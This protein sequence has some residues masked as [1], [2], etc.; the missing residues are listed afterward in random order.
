MFEDPA[1]AAST[2]RNELTEKNL[3]PVRDGQFDK[4][5]E[6]SPSPGSATPKEKRIR[7]RAVFTKN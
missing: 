4:R 7:F 2:G 3:G 6:R 1:R 5:A